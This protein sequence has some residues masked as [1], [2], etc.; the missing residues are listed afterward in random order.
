MKL[1]QLRDLLAIVERG[2]LRA[3]ARHLGQAQPALT[4]SIR[5][6]EQDLG[7][8]L[9][10][11]E[12]RGMVLTPAGKL[13]YQRASLVVQELRHAR[14]E[15]EQH[16]GQMTGTVVMGLSI[17]PHVGW[18]P[19]ALPIFR[20]KFPHIKLKVI[21]GLYPAIESGLRDGSIDFYL[22]A[23][24]DE[25]IESGL[26]STEITKNTRT[27]VARKN[28][29]LRHAQS[30]TDLKNA[31]WAS[32]SVS[33]NAENDLIDLFAQYQ[34]P[35]PQLMFQA[36]SALSLMVALSCTDLI[37]LLP[38]Q[39]NDFHL[40][41]DTLQVIHIQESLPAPSIVCIKRPGL[42]LTPAAD[43]LLEI[44]TSAWTL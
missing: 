37:A 10:E 29:P 3:A 31:Q 34:L 40:T 33:F 2:S 17:M 8:S 22:G 36:N 12:A 32:T 24:P 14:E 23:A 5:M 6:L 35:A 30:I 44:L 7:T 11:R 43:G 42:P 39:W 28:H 19:Q 13:F 18:L 20:E 1:N 9:F 38:V 41:R 25:A 27:V 21:E 16:S 4:R 26:I 15:I